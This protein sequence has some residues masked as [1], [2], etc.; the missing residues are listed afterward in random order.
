MLSF[1]CRTA[2]V[3]MWF[4][5]SSAPGLVPS[6]KVGQFP[7]FGNASAS[8][9]PTIRSTLEEISSC[10]TTSFASWWFQWLHEWFRLLF[11]A[12]SY[13]EH[14]HTQK[15]WHAGLPNP[16]AVHLFFP[17][18]EGQ[19]AL[20]SVPIQSTDRIDFVIIILENNLNFISWIIRIKGIAPKR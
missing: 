18:V 6:E 14:Q 9:F 16:I 1:N 12:M 4:E 8:P 2:K 15:R 20:D 3:G 10:F 7:R 11:Y 17:P 13:E 19:G 5:S